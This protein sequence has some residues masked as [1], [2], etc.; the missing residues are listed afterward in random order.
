MVHFGDDEQGFT[1]DLDDTRSTL[2]V[3]V[4]GFWGTPTADAL[5]R[6][7]LNDC[8]PNRMTSLV[9]D[10]VGLKPQREAG[11]RALGSLM[12]ALPKLGIKRA[13]LVTDSSLTKLQLMR[14]TKESGA[15]NRLELTFRLVE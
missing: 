14:I 6:A 7:V 4:W 11:Q 12:A 2:R 13:Q 8:P 5:V 9:L 3:R 10:A 1:V 15:R